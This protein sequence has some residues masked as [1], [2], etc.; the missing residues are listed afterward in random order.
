[1]MRRI[2]GLSIIAVFLYISH[3]Q[4]CE[5]KYFQQYN[6]GLK[7]ELPDAWEC[8]AQSDG[9]FLAFF[10]AP[11]MKQLFNTLTLEHEPLPAHV[12]LA[13]YVQQTH[14]R[15]GRELTRYQ[16]LN[17]QL[18]D[19]NPQVPYYLLAYTWEPYAEMQVFVMQ[20]ITCRSSEV[21]IITCC[22]PNDMANHY[23]DIFLQIFN[24]AILIN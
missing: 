11:E 14:A 22:A 21:I 18:S 1:M 3:Q 20:M 9:T 24:H 2:V 7:L 19:D 4:D 13:D 6:Y 15:N 10:V 23:K 12:P 17:Q 8:V 5:A 16:L